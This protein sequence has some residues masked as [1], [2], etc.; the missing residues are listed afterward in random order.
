MTRATSARRYA[1]VSFGPTGSSLVLWGNT[2]WDVRLP[3]PVRTFDAFSD[4]GGAC[5]HPRGDEVVLNSEVWDLRSEK[6]LRSVHALDGCKLSWTRTGDC[7]VASYRPPRDESILGA[8]RKTKH[9]LR[10]SFRAVD[11]ANDYAEIATVDVGSAVLDVS[12]DVCA[13]ASLCA[14][15]CDPLAAD[16]EDSVV[17]VYEAG[18]MRPTEEDSDA[19]DSD[20]IGD[21]RSEG[22]DDEI[23]AFFHGAL[24]ENALAAMRE[25]DDDDD[26]ERR[27]A[28]TAAAI[29]GDGAALAGLRALLGGLVA[30]RIRGAVEAEGAGVAEGEEE[31][32]EEEEDVEFS[33]EPEEDDSA[34]DDAERS[35]GSTRSSDSDTESD[36]VL[37]SLSSGDGDGDEESVTD[38][39][40]EASGE[41]DES[42]GGGF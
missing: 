24:D 41:D 31:E 29:A 25:D 9:P 5:F 19:E 26:D 13:D 17:R 8:V 23:G 39:R 22:D 15:E 6:L 16:F 14:A 30:D 34:G 37:L 27:A 33:L 28:R 35:S 40:G 36:S 18:R 20:E 4:G 42:S 12:W 11:G 32:E 38:S 3:H 1:D 10:C 2:L 7:A 21:G